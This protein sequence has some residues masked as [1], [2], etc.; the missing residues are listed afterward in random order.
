MEADL[1]ISGDA[2]ST[3]WL[4]LPAPAKSVENARFWGKYYDIASGAINRV[5]LVDVMVGHPSEWWIRLIAHSETASLGAWPRGTGQLSI[6]GNYE[7]DP[8]WIR[9]GSFP[10]RTVTFEGSAG[11]NFQSFTPGLAQDS[12][13]MTINAQAFQYMSI[14]DWVNVLFDIN[15]TIGATPPNYISFNVPRTVSSVGVSDNKIVLAGSWTSSPSSWSG[16]S[17]IRYD[18]SAS[19]VEIIIG[20]DVDPEEYAPSETYLISGVWQYPCTP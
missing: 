14:G 12:G 9:T 10:I 15:I 6:E 13:D 20:S 2:Q 8:G 18:R 1:I 5:I 19:S 3:F 11:S 16:E 17:Y 4:R 7:V